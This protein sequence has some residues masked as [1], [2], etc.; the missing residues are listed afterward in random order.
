MTKYGIPVP[1]E[2]RLVSVPLDLAG[3]RLVTRLF[4]CWIIGYLCFARVA[5]A[6]LQFPRWITCTPPASSS[7]AR[8]HAPLQFPDCITCCSPVTWLDHVHHSSFQTV[9]SVRS[10]RKFRP[11]PD[12]LNL[13]GTESTSYKAGWI[14]PESYPNL[15]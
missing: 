6:S 13:A 11:E 2:F 10:G 3:T 5:R 4:S 12:C 7:L 15:A 9:S 1:V 8:S 14:W